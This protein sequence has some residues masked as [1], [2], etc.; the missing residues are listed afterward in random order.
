MTSRIR[1]FL[2]GVVVSVQILTAVSAVAQGGAIFTDGFETGDACLWSETV[3]ACSTEADLET[4]VDGLDAMGVC[5]P[6]YT[7]P[8]NP[9]TVTICSDSLC[10][11][12]QTV[13]C[14]FWVS[15]DNPLV[16]L[17]SLTGVADVLVSN[18]AVGVLVEPGFDPCTIAV[19]NGAGDLYFSIGPAPV[20]DTTT[21]L[22]DTLPVVDVSNFTADLSGDGVCSL[23][24]SQMGDEIFAT[25]EQ[26]L[27]AGYR[28]ELEA[29]LL[30]RWLCD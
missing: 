17:V 8:F 27:T 26:Q 5:I 21:Q 2:A 30:D 29:E 20:C 9:Y 10:A 19:E 12:G 1:W 6:E 14:Q 23:I 25:V 28:G 7:E 11:D 13:G 4:V 18:G 3:N 24:I 22:I 15:T 16:D